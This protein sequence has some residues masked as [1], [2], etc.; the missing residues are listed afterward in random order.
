MVETFVAATHAKEVIDDQRPYRSLDNDQD[1]SYVNAS[2]LD[3][4]RPNAA[5]PNALND[6]DALEAK[7]NLSE[8]DYNAVKVKR[9]NLKQ[10]FLNEMAVDRFVAGHLYG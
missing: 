5:I 2:I 4:S 6:S 7:M 8:H 3:Y 10:F 1:E 9:S